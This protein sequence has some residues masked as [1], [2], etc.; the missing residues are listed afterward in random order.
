LSAEVD[1]ESHLARILP[2]QRLDAAIFGRRHLGSGDH[3]HN[4][5]SGKALGPLSSELAH[6]REQSTHRLKAAR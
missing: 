1:V 6:G 2:E 5:R 3:H 4:A